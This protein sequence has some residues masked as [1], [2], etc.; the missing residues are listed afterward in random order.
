MRE[1][2]GFGKVSLNTTKKQQMHTQGN[3]FP[4]DVNVLGYVRFLCLLLLVQT[5]VREGVLHKLD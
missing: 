4:A 2:V 5:S 1:Y 3:L